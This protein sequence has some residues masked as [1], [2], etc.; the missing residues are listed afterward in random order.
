[1]P[2]AVF[3]K[4][5]LP[6]GKTLYADSELR[7]LPAECMP[8]APAFIV[9]GDRDLYD[10]L[11]GL[12]LETCGRLYRN[13]RFTHLGLL[14]RELGI[15]AKKSRKAFYYYKRLVFEAVASLH[16]Y[17]GGPS[18]RKELWEHISA[19]YRRTCGREPS[20]RYAKA[21]V[22]LLEYNLRQEAFG[23]DG[24]VTLWTM[25]QGSGRVLRSDRYMSDLLGETRAPERGLLFDEPVFSGGREPLPVY[26]GR[27]Y[28][29]LADEG[30]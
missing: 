25:G 22:R 2:D 19:V 14:D 16:L 1:M 30:E 26:E 3:S 7:R 13:Y 23:G 5:T 12:K 9:Q 10:T 20:P 15:G 8:L 21:L 18:C 27:Y 29:S 11:L 24:V 6:D 17:G 28:L 4:L